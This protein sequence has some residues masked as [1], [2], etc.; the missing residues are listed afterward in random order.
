[1]KFVTKVSFIVKIEGK[2]KNCNLIE[3]NGTLRR[4]KSFFKQ[5]LKPAYRQD[6]V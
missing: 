2:I 6:I 4:L 5:F 3:I 1:M